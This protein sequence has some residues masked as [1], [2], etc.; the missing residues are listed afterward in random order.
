MLHLKMIS[1]SVQPRD[2]LFAKSCG[3]LSFAKN[4]DKI[5]VK[6]ISKIWSIKYRKK[7]FDHAK[8]S[9]TDALKTA[10][11]GV[12][13]KTAE[14]TGEKLLTQ[15]L[16]WTTV[17]LRKSHKKLHQIIIQKQLKVILIKKNLKKDIYLQKKDRKRLMIWY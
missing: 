2:K 13:R 16:S 1:C 17:K 8:Q 15:Y 14:P 12:I 9:A 10:S 7:H 3:F 11:K 4:M 6:N 5:I